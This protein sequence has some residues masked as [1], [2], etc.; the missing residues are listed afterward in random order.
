M[1][2]HVSICADGVRFLDSFAFRFSMNFAFE[3]STQLQMPQHLANIHVHPN[4]QILFFRD[5][6]IS[7]P[8]CLDFFGIFDFSLGATSSSSSKGPAPTKPAA[9]TWLIISK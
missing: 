8:N 1:I 5:T 6:V 4:V 2:Q 9:E 3:V 7:T